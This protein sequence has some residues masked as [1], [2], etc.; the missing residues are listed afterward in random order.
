MSSILWRRHFGYSD[1][2]TRS[3]APISAILRVSSA[4]SAPLPTS[5]T[6]A[7]VLTERDNTSS[8]SG[9]RDLIASRGSGGHN[10]CIWKGAHGTKEKRNA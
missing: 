10:L 5:Q 9:Y 6:F 2:L 1:Y 3:V 4:Q 8:K 7:A